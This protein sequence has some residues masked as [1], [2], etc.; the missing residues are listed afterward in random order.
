MLLINN[1]SYAQKNEFGVFIGSSGYFGDVGHEKAESTIFH[2]SPAFG[3]VY[4]LNT[5]DYLSFRSSIQTGTVKADD[6]WA[7]NPS[8]INRNLKFQSTIIDFNLGFEFNFFKFNIRKN[9]TIYSPYI[10]AGISGFIFNPKVLGTNIELQPLGTEGQ[11]S[12]APNTTEKYSRT[13]LSIPFGLG[14]KMNISKKMAISIEWTWRAAQTDYLDDVS[15]QYVDEKYLS[16]DA[17]VWANPSQVTI[18]PGKSRG[19]QNNNDWYN[20]TGITFS[21][22]IKNRPKKCPKAL[23]P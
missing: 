20:F 16:Q 10:F 5:H 17:I 1:A 13:A 2:Q 12:N 23:L 14:Y 18:P 3:V 4:K 22:K 7:T 6:N 15:T 8:I 11:G 21:Y 19:N 9:K